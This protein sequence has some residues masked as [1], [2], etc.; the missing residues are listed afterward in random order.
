MSAL[1]AEEVVAAEL[2]QVLTALIDA[3]RRAQDQR[4]LAQDAERAANDLEAQA[5]KLRLALYRLRGEKG[6][7]GDANSD[8]RKRMGQIQRGEASDA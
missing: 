6:E 8:N 4:R 3:N 5:Q 2:D 1:N 7:H